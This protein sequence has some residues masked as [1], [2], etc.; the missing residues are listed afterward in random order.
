MLHISALW[1]FGTSATY[2]PP[3]PP[4]PWFRWV[5]LVVIAPR[6]IYQQY[7]WNTAKQPAVGC[8]NPWANLRCSG[9]YPLGEK[10]CETGLLHLIILWRCDYLSNR[11]Y[12]SIGSGNALVSNRRHVI[13]WV[14]ESMITNTTNPYGATINSLSP[15]GYGSELKCIMF[16]L[17]LLIDT[18]RISYGIVLS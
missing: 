6:F 12:T 2:P 13:T 10:Y 1:Y 11:P 4:P 15:R 7:L 16:I 9:C 18:L 5:K 17:V 3:P 14:T 8:Y